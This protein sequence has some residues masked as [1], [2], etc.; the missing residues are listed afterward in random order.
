MGFQW[1]PGKDAIDQAKHLI[2]FRQAVEI[3]RGFVLTR[4]DTRRVYGEPR[5]IALGEYDQIVLSVVYT[6][7]GDDIRIISAWRAGRHE[8]EIYIQARDLRVRD[9]GAVR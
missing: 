6:T 2:G 1:D 4:E 8:R 7:R 9:D 5:F 3:F